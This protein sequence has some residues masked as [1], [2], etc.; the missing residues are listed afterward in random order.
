[1]TRTYRKLDTSL[2]SLCECKDVGTAPIESALQHGKIG[3]HP[4]C[5]EVLEAVEHDVVA[6]R[7]DF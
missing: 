3:D 5:V 1:M 6:F 4:T 2:L 7:S